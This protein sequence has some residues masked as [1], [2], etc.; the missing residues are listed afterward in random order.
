MKSR[1]LKV[2]VCILIFF[3][4]ICVSNLLFRPVYERLGK[5]FEGALVFLGEKVRDEF[6]LENPT[7]A[8][9]LRFCAE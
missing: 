4:L 9:P 3:S 1:F 6:G 2:G 8:Y 5:T 7:K